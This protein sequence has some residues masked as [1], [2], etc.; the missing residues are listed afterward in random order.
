MKQSDLVEMCTPSGRSAFSCER[1]H[2]HI[3]TDISKFW[4]D[5]YITAS[6]VAKDGDCYETIYNHSGL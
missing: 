5:K 4:A 1:L 6:E 2:S 3:S